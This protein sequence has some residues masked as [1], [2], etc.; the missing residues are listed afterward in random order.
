MTIL[1]FNLI[2]HSHCSTFSRRP[3]V[4]LLVSAS[5]VAS[6]FKRPRNLQPLLSSLAMPIQTPRWLP[7]LSPL[8]AMMGAWFVGVRAIQGGFWAVLCVALVCAIL[9]FIGYRIWYRLRTKFQSEIAQ[10]G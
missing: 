6:V 2:Q 5:L 8:T 10:G 1:S 9:P 7:W 3:R 4:T